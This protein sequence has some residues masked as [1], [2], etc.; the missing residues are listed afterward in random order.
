MFSFSKSP[1]ANSQN[2][3]R[4]P[5]SPLIS[6]G[7]E[8]QHSFKGQKS[9]SHWHSLPSVVTW[10][11]VSIRMQSSH[12]MSEEINPSEETSSTQLKSNCSTTQNNEIENCDA[13]HDIDQHFC[14]ELDKS[15]VSKIVLGSKGNKI[16]TYFGGLKGMLTRAFS[17]R[18]SKKAGKKTDELRAIFDRAEFELAEGEQ[19]FLATESELMSILISASDELEAAEGMKKRW[20]WLT[21]S[22]TLRNIEALKTKVQAVQNNLGTLRADFAVEHTRLLSELTRAKQEYTAAKNEEVETNSEFHPK[23]IDSP[24]GEREQSPTVARSSLMFWQSNSKTKLAPS[25][26]AFRNLPS[27][28]TWCNIRHCQS[29]FLEDAY[30]SPGVPAGTTRMSK[31]RKMLSS[32]KSPK[33]SFF[34]RMSLDIPSIFSPGSSPVRNV[35]NIAPASPISDFRRLPSVVSWYPTGRNLLEP[36]DSSSVLLV[37]PQPLSEIEVLSQDT[38]LGSENRVA[39]V[40]SQIDVTMNFKSLPSVVTWHEFKPNYIDVKKNDSSRSTSSLKPFLFKIFRQFSSSF[41]HRSISKVRVYMSLDDH[42]H[43]I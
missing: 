15:D 42:Q 23:A 21:Y 36:V 3:V 10:N 11:N 14:Q 39:S 7:H 9:Q 43:R 38:T 41:G 1:S 22:S 19:R 29:D 33:I 26:P 32:L 8:E 25:P 12:L 20:G 5:V 27:V 17:L 40:G 31:L 30:S 28:V 18:T 24:K 37:R 35:E 13:S 16:S 4:S 6:P 2:E 34:E